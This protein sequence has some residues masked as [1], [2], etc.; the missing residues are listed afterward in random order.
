[1][2]VSIVGTNEILYHSWNNH[3]IVKIRQNR[4]LYFLF[5]AIYSKEKYYEIKDACKWNAK[6]KDKIIDYGA[7]AKKP[8][9]CDNPQTG[10]WYHKEDLL[11]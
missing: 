8:C 2:V 11:D 9:F 5:G 10:R 4:G 6:K 3:C 1:M 7:P